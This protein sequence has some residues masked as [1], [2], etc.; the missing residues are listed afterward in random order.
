MSF[1][2]ALLGSL[3]QSVMKGMTISSGIEGF[4]SAVTLSYLVLAGLTALFQLISLNK[5][6]ELYN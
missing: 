5:A 6:M 1:A 3:Q 2:A 4:W